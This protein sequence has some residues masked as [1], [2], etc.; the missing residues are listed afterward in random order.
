MARLYAI[1]LG[2]WVEIRASDTPP[3]RVRSRAKVNV[4][5]KVYNP[6]TGRYKVTP[7]VKVL[8]SYTFVGGSVLGCLKPYIC[9]KLIRRYPGNMAA[10]EVPK[11]LEPIVLKALGR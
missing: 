2:N 9:M 3:K 1:A 7:L 10:I 11:E 4:K 5:Q 8:E 6:D